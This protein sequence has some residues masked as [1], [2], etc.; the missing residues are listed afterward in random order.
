MWTVK[1][2]T[3]VEPRVYTKKLHFQP[4]VPGIFLVIEWNVLVGVVCTLPVSRKRTME[5]SR[6]TFC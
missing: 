6:R 3:F 4:E 2:G 5:G 1:R